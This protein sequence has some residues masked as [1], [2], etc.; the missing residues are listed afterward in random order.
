MT[1]AT[2]P[3]GAGPIPRQATGPDR[4]RRPATALQ[5]IAVNAVVVL[6]IAVL[7]YNALNYPY[8]E[9]DEGTYVSQS[10]AVFTQGHLAPYTYFYDHPPGGWI[11]IAGWQVL[12]GGTDGLFG[13]GIASGRIFMILLHAGS[14]LLVIAA[15]RKLTGSLWAGLLAAL[16]FGLSP[17]GIEY[18]RR[19]LLDNLAAFWMLV[20]FLLLLSRPLRLNRVWLS[21]MALAV[22]VWSK[23]IAVTVL[24]A[25]AVL[26]ARRTAPHARWLSF[27]TWLTLCL[28]LISVYPLMALLRGELFSYGGLFGGGRSHVSLLCSLQWQA[29]RDADGGIADFGSGFWQYAAQWA[30]GNLLV[31]VGG[32]VA[33][34]ACVVLFRRDPGLSMLG[35]LILSF[36][37]FL[38]R[39]GLTLDFYL[40]PL[41]PFLAL[42][43]AAVAWRVAKMAG[44][45]VPRMKDLATGAA[46]SV[47]ALGCAGALVL[48][49]AGPGKGEWWHAR[50]AEGQQRAVDWVKEN[51]SP[52]SKIII[53][54]YMYPYL[55]DP[56]DPV[57]R[58][59]TQA[60][61]YWKAVVDPAVRQIFHSDWREVDYIIATPQLLQ[62]AQDLS[63]PLVRE[64]LNHSRSVARFDTG[65]PVDIRKVDP[66]VATS[67]Y[68]WTKPARVYGPGCMDR[69]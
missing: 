1:I 25:M 8:L 14:T 61:Y 53:D 26:A 2:P 68:A 60:H 31:V 45:Q 66:E 5:I 11:Q 33:A 65:L 6:N 43:F 44:D 15:G 38:G 22:A 9:N 67:G 40:V 20:A 29:D 18:H 69:V 46:Y 32:T 36:W 47:L 48:A 21:A 41:L 28:S 51:I 39:G 10:W 63:S 23:E 64:A 17:Y 35:W 12:T 59:F 49:I 7:G 27:W 50:P 34:I 58:P 55:H 42:A 13:S 3:R 52:Q 16:V 57:Q 37:L 56:H 24:P 54:M 4:G 62:D 19:V 30:S